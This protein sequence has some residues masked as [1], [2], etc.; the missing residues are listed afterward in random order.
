MARMQILSQ[1][2]SLADQMQ[3]Q[4]GQDQLPTLSFSSTYSM[5]DIQEA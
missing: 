4:V 3:Y 5:F 1:A 2:A